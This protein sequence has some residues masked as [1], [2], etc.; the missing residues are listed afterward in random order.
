MLPQNFVAVTQLTW[1]NTKKHYSKKLVDRPES[2]FGY[3]SCYN[4]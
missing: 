2:Y 3:R 4:L 1:L